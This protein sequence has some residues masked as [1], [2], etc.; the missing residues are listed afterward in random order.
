MSETEHMERHFTGGNEAPELENY[1]PI[2]PLVIVACIAALASLLATAHPLL[3]IIP[4]AA[5]ILSICAIVGVSVAN[6]RYSGRAAAVVALCV[7]A[8]VGSYAP[9]RTLSRE[10]A[11]NAEAR[12]KAEAWIS[13]LQQGRL[14]EAHQ[15]SMKAEERFKGPES[16]A[17][18][19]SEVRPSTPPSA[20]MSETDPAALS[21]PPPAEALKT[22]SAELATVKLQKLGAHAR[23]EHLQ[24][25]AMNYVNG[26]LKISQRYRVSGDRDGQ[27]ENVEFQITATRHENGKLASWSV[28]E[29]RLVK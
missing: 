13:L 5:M 10:R 28:G 19:Y 21:G 2:S 11:L 8:L 25:V 9:A 15:L 17:A 7:A 29:V 27:P 4:V 18:H 14:Q 16:L 1:R 24:T 3:W 6:S 23:I 26:D 22:F 12:A 20:S